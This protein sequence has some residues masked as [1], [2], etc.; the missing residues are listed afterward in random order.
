M[1]EIIKQE[2]H[3]LVDE[4]ENEAVLANAKNLLVSATI[5]SGLHKAPTEDTS[6]SFESKSSLD[7]VF[8]IWKNR[9]IRLNKIREQ[10]WQRQAD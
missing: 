9:N 8:G 3:D 10:Q 6:I 1:N 5:Q 2:I 4:C 7:E